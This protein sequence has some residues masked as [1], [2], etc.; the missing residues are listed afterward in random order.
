MV[1]LLTAFG[2]GLIGLLVTLVVLC[3]VAYVFYWLINYLAPPEPIKKIAVVILVLVFVLVL[4]SLLFGG[5][6]VPAL[7]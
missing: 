2:G 7:R 5:V 1:I 3:L 4:I 6:S